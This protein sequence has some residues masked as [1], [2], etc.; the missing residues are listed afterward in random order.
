MPSVIVDLEDDCIALVKRMNEGDQSAQDQLVQIGEAA[1]P[2]LTSRFPGPVR[3]ELARRVGEPGA[4]A[5]Q[6]GPIL[7]TLVRLGDSASPFLV[8]RTA[9]R[10]PEVRR[11][12]TW[13][14]G[15]MPSSDTARSV[16]R[17]VVDDSAEVRRAAIAAGR[18]MQDDVD[19]RT[20]L[21]DTLALLAADATQSESTRNAAIEALA[22]IRDGRAV[23]RLIPLLRDETSAVAKSA[24][25]ALEILTRQRLGRDVKAWQ[26]WWKDHGKRHRIEWLIEALDDDDVGVRRDAGDE[27]K[28][29]TKEY[30]GFYEDL[31][32]KERK[33][34][35]RRYREW[36]EEKG[37]ARFF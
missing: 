8:V 31:A 32:P 2:V 5:S 14:L 7:H 3:P 25:W 4:R 18:L 26:D 13:L 30:F 33:K 35:Q 37:K 27:L 36:W 9:D 15:E 11:W 24:R 17:R 10:D 16:A 6:C 20:A 22:D 19:A 1:I 29:L 28:T 34:V 21:R 23:P 12:A